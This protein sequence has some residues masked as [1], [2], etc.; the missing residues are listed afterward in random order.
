MKNIIYKGLG[1][2]IILK[3]AKTRE[4]R[5]EIL[6]DINHRKLEDQVF[7]TLLWLPA[8]FSG[9]HLS[10]VRGYMG[11]SQKEFATNLGLKT[12]ATISGWE[13][14]ESK[15]TGMQGTTEV[16]IRL[17]MAEFI[18]ENYF[19]SHFREFLEVANPPK[20]L[21]MKVA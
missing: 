3:G 4:F 1:F 13:G 2:P 18:K 12:H 19:A 16:I 20:N 7:K 10:F 15:A 9:A 11:L 6:P 8:H 21:E 14:K 17:L 5:G